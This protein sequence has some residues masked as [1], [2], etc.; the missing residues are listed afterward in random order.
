MS[1]L[2][3]FS[4]NSMLVLGTVTLVIFYW[5]LKAL[6]FFF[7]Y[8][9]WRLFYCKFKYYDQLKASLFWAGIIPTILETFI[10]LVVASFLNLQYPLFTFA[11][12]TLSFMFA[13]FCSY[14][15]FLVLLAILY[16]LSKPIES[17]ENKK[18]E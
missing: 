15:C 1:D 3:Y 2:G 10:E 14:A 8:C 13:L 4:H 7:W 17:L 12:D 9:M 16:V 6:F 11:G 18:F 5:I